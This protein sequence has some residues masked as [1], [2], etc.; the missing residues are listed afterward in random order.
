VYQMATNNSKLFHIFKYSLGS[1]L[2]S[3]FSAIFANFRQ[4]KLAFF[5]NTDVTI[6]IF[7]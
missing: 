4:K 2:W 1:M 6:K 7:A 3:Q 5:S